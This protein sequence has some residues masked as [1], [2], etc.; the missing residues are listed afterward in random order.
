M[1]SS[2][3]RPRLLVLTY[4]Y[5]R[6]AGGPFPG[7]HPISAAQLT[8]Q[9]RELSE[10]L[11]VATPEQVRDFCAGSN[12]LPRDAFFVTFDD[13]LV[14][15]LVA[16]TDVLA[17][18]GIRAAFFVPTRPLVDGRSPAVQKIHWLRA[19]TEPNAFTAELREQLPVPWNRYLLSE[20]ELE[21][22]ANMHIHDTADVRA[23]KFM[24]NFIVPYEIVDLATSSML[25]A[26]SIRESDFCRETF[27][28][29]QGLRELNDMGHVVGAHGHA[30]VPLSS[31][32]ESLLRHDLS[33]NCTALEQVLQRRPIWISYP[34]GREDAL[35]EDCGKVCQS[36]G[37]EL[38]MTLLPGWN[39]TAIN[40]YNVRRITPNELPKWL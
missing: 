3:R 30:H 32:S 7:I 28:G 38:G 1:T 40:Q 20:Q 37:F 23:I 14:D 2:N 11:H 21:R 34:Y 35:P 6:D 36:H 9:L 25:E 8:R 33:K 17:P 10:T 12:T 15:H 18:L 39:D 5:V 13:G 27:L 4:H 22:A 29:A 16:A 19:N 26:R 24:L 31:L